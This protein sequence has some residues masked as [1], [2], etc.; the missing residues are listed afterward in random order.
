MTITLL[1]QALSFLFH[2]FCYFSVQCCVE[3][4]TL[5]SNLLSELSF[6]PGSALMSYFQKYCCKSLTVLNSQCFFSVPSDCCDSYLSLLDLMLTVF[7]IAKNLAKN[8]MYWFE[9]NN[10]RLRIR[11]ELLGLAVHILNC[12]AVQTVLSHWVIYWYLHE[13]FC[14]L[15]LLCTTP[16]WTVVQVKNLFST[17]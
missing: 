7:S 4:V 3:S 15:I 9:C 6:H 14:W 16:A 2:Y 8:W 1:K 13:G 5:S 11:Q 12:K 10:W 17:A